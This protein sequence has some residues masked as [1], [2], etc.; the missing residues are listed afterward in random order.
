MRFSKGERKTLLAM[1]TTVAV[2]GSVAYYVTQNNKEVIHTDADLAF[3]R[4]G[5]ARFTDLN[6]NLFSF[7]AYR[8]HIRVVNIWATWSPLSQT[9][10]P[11]LNKVAG[12]L[13]DKGVVVIAVNRM[14]SG[15]HAQKFLSRL[16]DLDNVMFVLDPTDEYYKQVGGF[17]MP[18]TIVYDRS[19]AIVLHERGPM[20]LAEIRIALQKIMQQ[21]K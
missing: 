6:G 14:E 3:T 10:L 16:S 5:D 1:V 13:K 9:E 19:G 17:A 4:E 12:E 21:Q 20:K 11:A 15:D 7:D 2:A 8:D 18:E